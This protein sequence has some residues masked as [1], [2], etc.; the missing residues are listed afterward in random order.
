MSLTRREW[1]A[2]C[3]GA[4]TY[5]PILSKA[6]AAPDRQPMG[7]AIDSYALRR[8]AK[9]ASDPAERFDDPLVFLDYCHSLGAGGVQ[10]GIGARDEAYIA[11]VRSQLESSGMYLEGS[12]RLPRDSSDVDRFTAEVRTAKDCGAKVVRTTML[13]GRRYEIFDSAEGFRQAAEKSWESMLL[14]RPVVEKLG[15]RL[16]IENHKD[17]RSDDLVALLKRIDSPHIGVCVDTGNS[18]ALLEEP[19][20]VVE[21]LAP[22]AFTSHVKDM[23]V[24]EYADGFLLS[25]V[26]LGTGLLDLPKIIAMLHKAHPEIRFNL[27]MMT[28]DPLK[29][30]C[31][32]RKYW[33]TFA[34][35]PGRHLADTL[36]MVRAKAAKQPL[37]RI[38]GFS[39]EEK[40][41]LE[42]DN[43]R[44]CLTYAREHL[45]L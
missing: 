23:G 5:L 17:W 13:Q 7:V 18:I 27:E 38:N 36:A 32:T 14:A 19:L 37:P 2:G 26:P 30:P 40:L 11:K 34:D 1:L 28:R 45:G 12:L 20:E 41:K 29:V 4:L 6:Q 39:V 9:N 33:A 3:A 21:T 44:R 16:A 8:A 43:V 24:E 42:D 15:V 10:V 35:L 25:E 31:L 22:W